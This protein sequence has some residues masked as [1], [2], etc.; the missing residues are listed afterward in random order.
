MVIDSILLKMSNVLNISKCATTFGNIPNEYDHFQK[1]NISLH[2]DI[3][4]PHHK[5]FIVSCLS[6]SDCTVS[7]HQFQFEILEKIIQ[8]DHFDIIKD[9]WNHHVVLKSGKSKLLIIIIGWTSAC[10]FIRSKLVPHSSKLSSTH[11]INSTRTH[12]GS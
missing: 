9:K 4:T 12:T 2:R 1:F 7:L 5:L 3:T 8:T 6:S 10:C 11:S